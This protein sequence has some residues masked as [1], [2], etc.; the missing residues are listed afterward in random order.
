[1]ICFNTFL[2][3]CRHT[4]L[5]CL[6]IK[7]QKSNRKEG[8]KICSAM[9]TRAWRTVAAK[10]KQTKEQKSV[11]DIVGF[12]STLPWLHATIQ[13]PPDHS[14]GNPIACKRTEIHYCFEDYPVDGGL[15]KSSVPRHR[16]KLQGRRAGDLERNKSVPNPWQ[17]G[18]Q[19]EEGVMHR[20]RLL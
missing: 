14:Q 13:Q 5:Q 8:V 19:A 9:H 12:A 10:S 11:G 15:R 17:W 1:M 16:N 3:T 20:R 18:G 4:D 7:P 6:T 2:E